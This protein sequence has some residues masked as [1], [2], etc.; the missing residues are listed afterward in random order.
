VTAVEYAPY[1]SPSGRTLGLTITYS[2]ELDPGGR[3]DPSLRVMQEDPA[4]GAEGRD[5]MRPL[6]ARITPRPHLY[7]EPER[8]A[9][10]IPGLLLS[11]ALYH[12][13]TR[14]RFAVQLAPAFVALK[15]DRV[16]PCLTLTHLKNP[17][18]GDGRYLQMVANRGPSTYRVYIGRNAFEGRVDR[19]AGEGTLYQNWVDEGTLPCPEP[20]L[21][22]L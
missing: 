8:E 9:D 11:D 17:H 7:H 22:G 13:G 12:S 6:S 19:F 5:A 14:Y 18:H 2:I 16:T 21:P 15:Q 3:Y 4:S 10:E 20:K 1:L